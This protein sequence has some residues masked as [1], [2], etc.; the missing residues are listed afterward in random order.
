[1]SQLERLIFAL[2]LVVAVIAFILSAL[3]LVK[4]IRLGQPDGRLQG[5]FARRLETM[6]FYAFAQKRVIAEGFG[7]NHLI[8]FWGFMVLFMANAEFVAHGLFPGFSLHVLG[9]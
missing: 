3:R 2:I 4:L 1:M 8:L 7:Y 6:L 9:P 5:E